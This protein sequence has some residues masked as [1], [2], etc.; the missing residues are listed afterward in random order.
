MTQNL[1]PALFDTQLHLL[2]CVP[3]RPLSTRAVTVSLSVCLTVLE[4]VNTHT[5]E[6]SSSTLLLITTFIASPFVHYLTSPYTLLSNMSLIPPAAGGGSSN[7]S[8]SKSPFLT[9]L[10]RFDMYR[11][12]PAA[13]LTEQTI[14][15]ASISVVAMFIMSLLF[16]TEF[17]SLFTITVRHEMHVDHSLRPS[18]QQQT[19]GWFGRTITRTA[20]DDLMT[21]NLNITLPR[22]PCAI[23]EVGVQD[24]IGS[25]IDFHSQVK[26]Y[27]TD[28]S[29][30]I[31]YVRIPGARNAMPLSGDYGGL[32]QEQK[33]EG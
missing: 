26:K 6:A 28:N 1:Y 3:L 11:S 2:T 24:V 27:R 5:F 8:S 22:M 12:I 25:N 15:G 21:I 14:A 23:T 20:D 17:I 30:A 7:D 18:T 4:L 10:K 9:A 19:R 13:S 31:K 33:E 29:G 16:L 32:A